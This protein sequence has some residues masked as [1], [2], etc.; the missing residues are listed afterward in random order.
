MIAAAFR[1]HFKFVVAFALLWSFLMPT[2]DTVITPVSSAIPAVSSGTS[3]CS[4]ASTINQSFEK[5]EEALPCT[6]FSL[7]VFPLFHVISTIRLRHTRAIPLLMK[8]L[9]LRPI[10]FTSNYVAV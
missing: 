5:P 4:A 8:S 9:L 7:L 1:K 10:K 6:V 2:I 3:G